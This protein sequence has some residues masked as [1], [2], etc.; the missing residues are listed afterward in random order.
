MS[1]TPEELDL[2]M[3]GRV[4]GQLGAMRLLIRAC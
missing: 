1:Y 3:Q 2:E 4:S